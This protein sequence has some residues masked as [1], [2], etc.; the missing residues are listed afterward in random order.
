MILKRFQLQS[1]HYHRDFQR[2]SI[3]Q[4]IILIYLS[5]EINQCARDT[6]TLPLKTAQVCSWSYNTP[7]FYLFKECVQCPLPTTLNQIMVMDKQGCN[8]NWKIKFLSCWR[9]S[10]M[11]LHKLNSC[12]RVSKT[13]LKPYQ[14]KM[15]RN[16]FMQI[17]KVSHLRFYYT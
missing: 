6:Q 12:F 11:K 14:I 17:A 4:R 10:K 7:Q 13:H 3:W 16:P 9:N 5:K 15:F 2:M 8:T 1:A